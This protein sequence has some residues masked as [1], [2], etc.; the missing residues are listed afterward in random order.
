M[1]YTNRFYCYH[2]SGADDIY[3]KRYNQVRSMVYLFEEMEYISFNLRL[4]VACF[5]P[6]PGSTCKGRSREMRE[7]YIL[8]AD[9]VR[10][11]S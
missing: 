3:K 10:A 6:S 7:R 1:V 4:Y 11:N 9:V 8:A 2:D 5:P